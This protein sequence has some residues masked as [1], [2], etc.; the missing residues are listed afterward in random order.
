MCSGESGWSGQGLYSS[1]VRRMWKT[2]VPA[3]VIDRE[4]SPSSTG[5]P[6]K[7]RKPLHQM[8]TAPLRIAWWQKKHS[9]TVAPSFD[10]FPKSIS[11]VGTR[12]MF[13]GIVWAEGREWAKCEEGRRKMSDLFLSFC[14]FASLSLSQHSKQPLPAAPPT[15][16]S[17]HFPHV[18]EPG[19]DWIGP[20]IGMPFSLFLSLSIIWRATG[21]A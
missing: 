9:S 20:G 19:C 11:A 18:I 4:A 5:H 8:N 14:V 6:T 21:L 1:R 13:C 12:D 15:P 16:I 7:G 3:C 17:F 10:L 2:H